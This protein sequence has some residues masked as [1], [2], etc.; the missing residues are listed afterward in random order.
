MCLV[1]TYYP[2]IPILP[3]L[4]VLYLQALAGYTKDYTPQPLLPGLPY[5]LWPMECNWN[6]YVQLPGHILKGEGLLLQACMSYYVWDCD[7][8][9]G[10]PAAIVHHVVLLGIKN[11]LEQSDTGA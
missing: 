5:Q 3:F 8:M 7:V 4:T 11:M 2:Q 10:A 9:A 1:K 6:L